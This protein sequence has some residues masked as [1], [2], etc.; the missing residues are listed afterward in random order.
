MLWRAAGTADQ[1]LGAF[2]RVAGEP[3]GGNQIKF[4]ADGGVTYKGLL[5]GRVDDVL[6]IAVAYAKVSNEVRGADGDT[7][8]FT[9]IERPIRDFETVLEVT[10]KAQLA[11]WWT[12]Q[13]DL[14]FIF[15]PGGNIARPSDP[16]DTQAIP[17][18]VVIGLRTAV[19]F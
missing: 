5:P 16:T 9:G 13:P 12:V 11:A 7:R 19:T 2:L 8:R 15:H 4:Y 3:S 6:G 10:Y 17:N 18:A 14:Q 1:G